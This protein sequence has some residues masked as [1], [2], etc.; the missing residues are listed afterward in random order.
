[1]ERDIVDRLRAMAGPIVPNVCTEAADEIDR[2]RAGGCARDQ[3]TTQYCAEAMRLQAEIEQL[4]RE[5]E[6]FKAQADDVVEIDID[7]IERVIKAAKSFGKDSIKLSARDIW[8]M[9]SDRRGREEPDEEW[10]DD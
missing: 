2:L 1:M 10:N 6:A 7:D 5:R 9:A 3:K 8:R 4:T